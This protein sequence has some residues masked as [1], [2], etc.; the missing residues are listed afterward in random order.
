[1][2]NFFVVFDASEM[3]I[4]IYNHTEFVFRY[5]NA[6]VHREPLCNSVITCN[7]IGPKFFC[8]FFN[9]SETLQL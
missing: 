9:A 7:F 3:L 8:C 1:M 2:I 5:V 4:I 6:C